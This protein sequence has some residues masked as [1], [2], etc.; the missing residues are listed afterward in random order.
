MNRPILCAAALLAACQQ[1]PPPKPAPIELCTPSVTFAADIGAYPAHPGV[2]RDVQQ[3]LLVTGCDGG[4]L[5]QIA[6]SARVIDASGHTVDSQVSLAFNGE[7][8]PDWQLDN[9][10]D[11]GTLVVATVTFVPPTSGTYL[12]TVRFEPSLGTEQ[13]EVFTV[14]QTRD[15]GSRHAS[16]PND[17]TDFDVIG[18]IAICEESNTVWTSTSQM[19]PGYAFAVDGADLWIVS[20]T[21][22]SVSQFD[23][24]TPVIQAA[25]AFPSGFISLQPMIMAKNGEALLIGMPGIYTVK[26]SVFGLDVVLVANLPMLGAWGA[27]W[28]PEDGAIFGDVRQFCWFGFGSLDPMNC[29]PRTV[30]GGD[31]DLVWTNDGPGLAAWRIDGGVPEQVPVLGFDGF[32]PMMQEGGMVH[33]VPFSASGGDLVMPT[34]EVPPSL[35]DYGRITPAGAFA[36]HFAGRHVY[37]QQLSGVSDVEYVIR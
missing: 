20:D 35:A 23:G 36:T 21:G 13:F 27:Q 26:R 37:W 8:N 12:G 14:D 4:T 28:T 10:D 34:R 32:T 3:A 29:V 2:S 11:G 5:D 30:V 15:G 7:N 25:G 16:V 24:G 18:E 6:A 31:G 33:G 22:V 17:C 9:S 1:P 19:A